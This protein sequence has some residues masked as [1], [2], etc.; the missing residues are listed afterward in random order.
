MSDF[1]CVTWRVCGCG[2]PAPYLQ[3]VVGGCPDVRL[4][5]TIPENR[6]VSTVMGSIL[7]AARVAHGLELLMNIYADNES[8][9]FPLFPVSSGSLA[10]ARQCAGCRK[11]FSPR[12]W[13][14][15]C[16]TVNCRKKRW[17]IAQRTGTLYTQCV[18]CKREICRAKG[19]E[20]QVFCAASTGR[21]CRRKWHDEMRSKAREYRRKRKWGARRIAAA[22]EVGEQTVRRWLGMTR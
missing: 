19:R 22:L 12:R 7:M 9:E 16:C 15:W 4:M 18:R 1:R 5:T 2:L 10:G 21:N 20:Y 14:H 6:R 11:P 8:K 3:I 17:R 13:N